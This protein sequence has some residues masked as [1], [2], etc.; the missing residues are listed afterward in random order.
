[1]L[2]DENAC[3]DTFTRVISDAV[4]PTGLHDLLEELVLRSRLHLAGVAAER[5]PGTGQIPFDA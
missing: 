1:M 3:H 5:T 4:K 2:P